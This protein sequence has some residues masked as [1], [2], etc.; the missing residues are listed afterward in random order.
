MKDRSVRSVGVVQRKR[1]PLILGKLSVASEDGDTA[2]EE[3]AAA[4]AA[5]EPKKT[6]S[7]KFSIER[8][9]E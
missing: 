8:A 6:G 5:E 7:P 3:E 9:K 2:E 1:R 4:A